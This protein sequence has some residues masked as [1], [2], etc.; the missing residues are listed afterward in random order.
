MI[1]VS[2]F[3]ASNHVTYLPAQQDHFLVIKIDLT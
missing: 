2:V 3:D 1:R